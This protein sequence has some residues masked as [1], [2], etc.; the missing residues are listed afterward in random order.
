MWRE[1]FPPTCGH[2]G[3]VSLIDGCARGLGLAVTRPNDPFPWSE[4]F[5]H[6]GR[7]CPAVLFGLGA[8]EA[9]PA[10]HHPRYDF[11]DELLPVGSALL[12]ASVRRLL[13][14]HG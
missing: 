5:G 6:F 14:R 7:E 11:P 13:E 2:P 12:E 3:L 10:L 1:E 8:G 9:V 4:D